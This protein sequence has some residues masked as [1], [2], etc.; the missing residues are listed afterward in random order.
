[1]QPLTLRSDSHRKKDFVW[2]HIF[3]VAGFTEIRFIKL[4]AYAS[5]RSGI[6]N[7]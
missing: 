3:S 5:V 6:P 2:V 1:M 4:R 7:E